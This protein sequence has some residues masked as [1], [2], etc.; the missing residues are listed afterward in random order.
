MRVNKPKTNK[1]ILNQMLES[2]G[3]GG[4]IMDSF[5]SYDNFEEWYDDSIDDEDQDQ[6]LISLAELYFKWLSNGDIITTRV[7]D[8]DGVDEMLLNKPYKRLITYG[9]GYNDVRIILVTF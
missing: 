1:D 3:D 9:M 8:S 2:D 6:N 5:V 4:T 7:E